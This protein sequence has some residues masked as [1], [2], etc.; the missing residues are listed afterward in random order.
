MNRNLYPLIALCN[1]LSLFLLESNATSV[2]KAFQTSGTSFVIKPANNAV[3]VSAPALKITTSAIE[4]ATRYTIEL[5][6]SQDFTGTSLVRNSAADHQRTLT[7]T[8]LDYDTRYYARAKTN[9]SE[10][11][12]TTSF[13]TRE[14]VFPQMIDP[15]SG[16]QDV[17]PGVLKLEISPV[18]DASTYTVQLSQKGDFTGP[19]L[20]LTSSIGSQTTFVFQGLRHGVT[21]FVRAKSDIS[22]KFGPIQKF[23]T[24]ERIT[25]K[26]LWGLT[27][28]GGAH[29]GGTIFSFSV[30]SATFT[31]H[32]DYLESG[33]YPY[34]YLEGS[35]IP[36]PDGGFYGNSE[37]GRNGTCSNG[38]IFYVSPQGEFK[39]LSK[40]YFHEGS[41][42]LASNN[43]LYA[44]DDWINYFQGGIIRMPA[45][46]TE[47][48]LSHVLFR[49]KSKQQGQNPKSQLVELPDG[50]LYGLMPFGGNHDAGVVYKIKLDGRGFQVIHHFNDNTGENPLGGLTIGTDGYLYGTTSAGGA[51]H[52]GTLF[53]ISSSSVYAKLYD[54]NGS[55]GSS[56]Q[57]NIIERNGRVY[58]MTSAGGDFNKGTIFKL[59]TDGTAFK[60][61]FSFNGVNGEAP[62]TTPT[63]VDNVI[64]GTTTS[65]GANGNGV[66]FNIRL[67]GSGFQKLHDFS[68]E[69]GANPTGALLL[70]EDF[71]VGQP[72]DDAMSLNVSSVGLF[73]NPFVDDFT[74]EIKTTTSEPI[75]LLVTDI[76]GQIL[77]EKSEMTNVEI[78]LGKDLQKGVY[79]LKIVRGKE[80]TSHRIVK[81]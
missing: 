62:V 50:Y 71:F 20:S 74:A 23:R 70:A 28:A 27:S 42:M 58:G 73:P 17:N 54:F 57:G 26:R 52:A 38:E 68:L 1:V 8:G 12:K 22:T 15:I 80:V 5:N 33:E 11:G 36:A 13:M 45:T 76:H 24:R 64:Y 75:K 7:F 66:L 3:D 31:K 25:H 49:V 69:D 34:S 63:L 46:E 44:V 41:I 4:G 53:K 43:M 18:P 78:P 77:T 29:E 14:E 67:D 48:D 61:L 47:F 79:V 39:L 32:H 10:Y 40:P 30:D 6:T 60:K 81:K 2:S 19:I 56:P 21:Y 65:G 9:V 35:L 37:C 16:E 55:M 72:A 59:N 51:Y